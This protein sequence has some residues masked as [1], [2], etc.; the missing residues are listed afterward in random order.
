MKQ[1]QKLLALPVL[2][3]VVLGALW[4]GRGWGRPPASGA[5]VA[6]GVEVNA[7]TPPRPV[8]P[9]RKGGGVGAMDVS[10]RPDRMLRPPDPARRFMDFTPEQRVDFARRGQGP[11]G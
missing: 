8:D 6:E 5:R 11:G 3:M 2:A 7:S 9:G 4:F 10:P 1:N